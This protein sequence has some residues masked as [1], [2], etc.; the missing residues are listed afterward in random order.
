MLIDVQDI[1]LRV[2]D[3]CARTPLRFERLRTVE[4]WRVASCVRIK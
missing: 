2:D 4:S 3:S 1:S